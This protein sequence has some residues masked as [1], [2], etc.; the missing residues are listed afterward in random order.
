MDM[1][2]YYRKIR[3]N[4]E[5]IGEDAVVVKSLETPDGGKAGVLTEVSRRNAAILI[6]ES[7]AELASEEEAR[8]FRDA[9]KSAKHAIDQA[10]AGRRVQMSLVPSDELESLKSGKRP[11]KG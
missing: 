2:I 5:R 8:Q 9:V 3:E 1:R 11:T 4:E 10:E 6:T 7:R